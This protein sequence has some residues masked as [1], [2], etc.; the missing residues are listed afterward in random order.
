MLPDKDKLAEKSQQSG[1]ELINVSA[2][3]E[4]NNKYCFALI[5]HFLILPLI[6]SNQVL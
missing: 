6:L 2:D 3:K 1:S 5:M 4:W